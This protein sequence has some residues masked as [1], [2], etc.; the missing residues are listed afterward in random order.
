MDNCF[1]EIKFFFGLVVFIMSIYKFILYYLF[2]KNIIRN[3]K[4]ESNNS[5]YIIKN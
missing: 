4:S 1:L 3:I 2:K 5:F